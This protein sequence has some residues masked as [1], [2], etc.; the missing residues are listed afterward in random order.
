MD[1]NLIAPCGM[2]CSICSGYLAF[3]NDVK[4]KGIKIP[5]CVGCRPRDKKCAF[6]KKR[7]SLLSSGQITYCY[8]CPEFPCANLSGI[9]K[10]YRS[11]FRMSMIHNLEYIRENG[12]EKF[13]DEESTK[14]RCP[15]CGETVCCHNGI[16]FECGLEKLRAK[17]KL[18]R[19][20]DN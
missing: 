13:L 2:N 9:D 12:I 10:R 19:W 4:G 1:E 5:Y 16:C 11:F 8:E 18:Y 6:L 17:K 20:E 3:K 15:N 14:W 7:C